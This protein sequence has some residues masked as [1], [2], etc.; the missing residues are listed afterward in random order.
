M[1]P[2]FLRRLSATALLLSLCLLSP[3]WAEGRDFLVDAD[4]LA[5]EKEKNKELVILEV[6]YHPHRYYTVGH[7]EGAVQVQRF[8]DLGDN[9][10]KPIMRFPSKEKFEKTLRS[11]GVNNNSTIVL[12]DDSSTALVSR[13]YG[14]LEL[15]GYDMSKVKIL[16]GGTIGW[17]GFNELTKEL[18]PAPKEGNVT[19]KEA[20]P[21]ML[22]EWMDVYDDVVSRRD[23]KVVLVDARPADMYSGKTIKH[24]VQGG[25]IPGAINIVSL[26]GT[27]GQSQTWKPAADIEAM[28]KD[29]PKDKT[30]YLYCHDGFR[31]SLGFLQ[32]KSLGYKDVRFVNGGWSAW[33]GAMTLPIVQGDKPYDDDYS[34]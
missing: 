21:E 9:L 31:M 6:R 8:K 29:I 11:W 22:V 14:T 18:T 15:F 5:A 23:E 12:Y 30:V 26:D 10:A 3:A 19:L 13:L 1:M 16:D 24:A 20:N 2:L 28:Y 17:T 4:W 33:D 32:L 34:L 7:I 27:D 25:H